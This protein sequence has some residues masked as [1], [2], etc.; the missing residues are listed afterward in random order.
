MENAPTGPAVSSEREQHFLT[1]VHENAARLG[2]I[3]RVYA[4]DAEG[5]KDLH[6]E[7]L[8]QLWRALPSF[9]GA[10]SPSTWLYRVALNT[11]LAHARRRSVRRE[12]SLDAE[13]A[14][15][16]AGATDRGTT[17]DADEQLDAAERVGRLYAAIDRLN[18]V[19]RMLVTMYLDDRSYHEMA[20][21]LGISAGNVGVK[22]HRIRKVLARRLAEETA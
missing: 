2:R 14:S 6:Q 15:A 13:N 11:A 22:L 12:T 18:V 8:L 19:D 1:L 20:D 10:S 9:A 21:V 7:I 16:D 3:C 4:P 17:D 5:R